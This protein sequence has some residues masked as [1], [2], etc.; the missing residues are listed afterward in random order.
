M[1]YKKLETFCLFIVL[2]SLSYVL[3]TSCVSGQ[4]AMMQ[5]VARALFLAAV[6]S[7]SQVS[8]RYSGAHS[9][10]RGESSIAGTNNNHDHY[11]IHKTQW[12]GVINLLEEHYRQT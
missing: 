11:L 7:V 1:A 5:G 2:K 8:R 12:S 6:F 4:P 3:N 9:M 10:W